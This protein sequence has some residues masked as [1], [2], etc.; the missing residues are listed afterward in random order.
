MKGSFHVLYLSIIAVLVV[1]CFLSFNRGK[2]VEVVEKHTTDTLY[3]TK[4]DTIKEIKPIYVERKTTD[5]VFIETGGKDILPLPLTQKRFTKENI[6]DIWISGIEP[7]N[8][9][10][11]NIFKNTEYVTIANEIEKTVYKEKWNIYG[12]VGLNLIS[13]TFSPKIGIVLTEPRRWLI[14]AEIGLYDNS[15]FYGVNIGY[16]INN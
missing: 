3:L 6:Y 11:A 1:V 16:K 5:T 8:L 4:V 12:F 13:R 14:S 10:S 2:K 9:D 15:A 7:L